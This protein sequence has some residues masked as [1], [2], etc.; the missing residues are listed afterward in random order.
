MMAWKEGAN[1]ATLTVEERLTAVE[2]ELAEIKR[3][4]IVCTPE[5]DTPWWE[6][7]FGAFANSPE[8]E[9]MCQLGRE[10]RESLRP[11]DDVTDL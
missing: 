6:Q 11:K 3:K 5:G 4:M 2:R 10:Y 1:M 9:L 7:R 8:Y